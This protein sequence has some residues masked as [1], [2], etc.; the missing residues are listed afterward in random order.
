MRII[1]FDHFY[2]QDLDA[3]EDAL[4]SRDELV[5][6]PYRRWHRMAEKCFPRE[7]F[8]GLERAFLP[9]LDSA[10]AKYRRL[11]AQE[12]KWLCR[13]HQP[14][15]LLLPSDS[16]FYVRPFITE[17]R[18]RGVSTFVMQKETTISPMV[19]EEH[20]LQVGAHVPFMSD[21]MTVCSERHRQ[22]WIRAGT[23]PSLIAVTGQ[24]R[25]DVYARPSSN[26]DG[27][28]KRLLYLSYDDSAYL[29]TD[30]GVAFDG[31]W[32]DLRLQT[33]RAISELSADW[34]V[35][36]KVHPQQARAET[37]LGS[38][39][40]HANR[41]ADTRDLIRECDVVVGFQTTAIYEAAV[42]GKPV[43]YPAWGDTFDRVKSTLNSFETIPGLV[44]WARSSQ[45][46]SDYLRQAPSE[47]PRA[48]EAARAEAL[49]HLG[50]VDGRASERTLEY[51]RKY[52]SGGVRPNLD[53]IQLIRNSVRSGGWPVSRLVG[54][55]LRKLRPDLSTKFDRAARE[56][57]G[58]FTEVVASVRKHPSKVVARRSALDGDR[59]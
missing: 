15:L 59:G 34:A 23:D 21:F 45:E 30:V 41:Y 22:F 56:Y 53:V 50:P 40:I 14:E 24:P 5:R 32:R 51:M 43:I 49:I 8:S 35:T 19:M 29:P 11:V 39:V 2:S 17:F 20:S 4:G 28:R 44:L 55:A 52:A 12:V 25:F 46:L 42:C 54:V 27:S 33:E 18:S 3:L 31:S 1:A 57:R 16:F 58:I 13:S 26:R 36:V 6:I 37:A 48:S 47:L 9:D 7:A 10:W 38:R